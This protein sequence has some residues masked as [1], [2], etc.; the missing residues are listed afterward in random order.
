LCSGR[1]RSF[2][3]ISSR[4]VSS[5]L[6]NCILQSF[7]FDT[8]GHGVSQ[9]EGLASRC[10]KLDDAVSNS[11]PMRAR[12][13]TY[14]RSGAKMR[15]SRMDR[16]PHLLLPFG[17]HGWPSRSPTVGHVLYVPITE[18]RTHART[19]RKLNRTDLRLGRGREID[20]VRHGPLRYGARLPS[21]DRRALDID[22][23][24]C[25]KKLSNLIT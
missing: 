13:R 22:H 7:F 3:V 16:T 9:S 24:P 5:Q 12:V 23:I 4:L 17:P 25:C 19:Q 21:I 15:A 10:W 18:K 2:G 20:Y 14:V 1:R 8:W 6:A 11:G